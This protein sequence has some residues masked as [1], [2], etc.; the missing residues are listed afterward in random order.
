MMTVEFDIV[1]NPCCFSDS[2]KLLRI[3]QSLC[4]AKAGLGTPHNEL[5]NRH[6]E[7]K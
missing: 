5:F 3:R 4:D 2:E 1:T 6:P 7:W